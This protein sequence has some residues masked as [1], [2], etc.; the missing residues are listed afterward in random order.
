MVITEKRMQ[1]AI[2]AAGVENDHVIDV[3]HMDPAFELQKIYDGEINIEIGWFWDCGI[4]IRLGDKMNG[5][6]P[7]RR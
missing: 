6:L 1:V 7:R 5:T 2:Q 4:T 3:L